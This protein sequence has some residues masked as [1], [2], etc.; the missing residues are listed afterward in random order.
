MEVVV[1]ESMLIVWKWKQHPYPKCNDSLCHHLTFLFACA[2]I[3]MAAGELSHMNVNTF[4]LGHLLNLIK[5]NFLHL[6]IYGLLKL[7]VVFLNGTIA[8][9]WF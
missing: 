3:A 8:S 1:K 5:H 4:V 6:Y 2:I 7:L 9:F